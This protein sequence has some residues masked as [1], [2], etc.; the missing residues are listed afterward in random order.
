MESSILNIF[1]NMEAKPNGLCV[2]VG[3]LARCSNIV[4]ILNQETSVQG[5]K[6]LSDIGTNALIMQEVLLGNLKKHAKLWNPH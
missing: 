2:G 6:A 4:N 3:C 5:L 1:V